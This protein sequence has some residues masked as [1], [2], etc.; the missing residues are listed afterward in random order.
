VTTNNATQ[1][2]LTQDGSLQFFGISGNTIVAG[3]DGLNYASVFV[4]SYLLRILN[5]AFLLRKTFQS[6]ST[7]P[8]DLQVGDEEGRPIPDAEAQALAAAC[9]VQVFFSGED[10]SP[11]CA[12]YDEGS[13]HFNLK[14]EKS[15]PSGRYAITVKIFAGGE[16]ASTDTVHVQ[17]EGAGEDD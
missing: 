3:S 8:I 14:T 13:F 2:L 9:N 7:I 4:R 12:R 6:G 11:G 15:L 16:L 1:K 5:L 17:L 10:R